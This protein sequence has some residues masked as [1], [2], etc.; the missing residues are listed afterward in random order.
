MPVEDGLVVL[1]AG[2]TGGMGALLLKRLDTCGLQSSKIALIIALDFFPRKETADDLQRQLRTKSI[3]LHWD[4]A[5]FESTRSVTQ[6]IDKMAPRL[7]AV[8]I[9]TGIGFHGDMRGANAMSLEDSDRVLQ[10]LLAVNA[11]GP[12]LLAQWCAGKLQSSKH[13]TGTMLL[14]SSYSGVVGLPHRAAYCASKFALNGYLEAVHAEYPELKIVLVCPTSVATNFRTNWKA[15]MQSRGVSIANVKVNDADLTAEDCVAAV[16]KEFDQAAAH[17]G[18][19]YVILPKGKTAFS[20][21]AVRVP[22][23]GQLVRPRI[24]AKSSKL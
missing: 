17:G 7:D 12:S 1:V 14:L 9:T 21:W 10:R 20:F 19:Q 6:A 22:F 16:W 4:A 15:D 23:L 13:R 24:L 2:V 18:L 5:S 11:V 3:F 8:L